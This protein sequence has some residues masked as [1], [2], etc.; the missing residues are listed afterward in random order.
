M[1]GNE[2]EVDDEAVWWALITEL[3]DEET[4]LKQDR[5][6]CARISGLERKLMPRRV[7]LEC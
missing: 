5:L 4:V 3:D 2:E 7:L 1:V 6:R